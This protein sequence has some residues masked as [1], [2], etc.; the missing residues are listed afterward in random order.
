MKCSYLQSLQ[1]LFV[2][3]L[4]TALMAC[5]DC[6]ELCLP[7]SASVCCT[8]GSVQLETLSPLCTALSQTTLLTALLPPTPAPCSQPQSSD[9]W[10]RCQ[11]L[12]PGSLFGAH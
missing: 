2:R 4:C 9:P 10:A 3:V 11:A 12:W 5:A 6:L 7:H 8:P 1:I